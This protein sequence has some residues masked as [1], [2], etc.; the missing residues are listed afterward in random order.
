[1]T[2]SRFQRLQKGKGNVCDI[3]PREESAGKQRCVVKKPL[4][5]TIQV[6]DSQTGKAR[7]ARAG[8]PA[9]A[10]QA[11]QLPSSFLSPVFHF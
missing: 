7:E 9:V 2:K 5:T 3:Q 8:K 1:M 4:V 10:V 11:D 6:P